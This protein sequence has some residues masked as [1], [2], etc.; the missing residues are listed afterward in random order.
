MKREYAACSSLQIAQNEAT[1]CVSPGA[2]GDTFHDHQ[3]VL[4]TEAQTESLEAEAESLVV[5]LE[6]LCAPIAS[7]HDQAQKGLKDLSNAV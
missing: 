7:L 1:K 3:T 4:S 2:K 6:K 5:E